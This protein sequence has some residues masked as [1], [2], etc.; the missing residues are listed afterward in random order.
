[1]FN[2]LSFLMSSLHSSPFRYAVYFLAFIILDLI[3]LSSVPL[4]SKITPKY[5]LD[6]IQSR[7][8]YTISNCCAFPQYISIL[9]YSNSCPGPISRK[10]LLIYASYIPNLLCHPLKLLNHLQTGVYT[11]L[12][13]LEEY[14]FRS[15]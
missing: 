7:R 14:P 6:E 15:I 1:M 13:F 3:S 9:F 5:I 10:F 12:Y 2:F 8:L 11:M 4:V